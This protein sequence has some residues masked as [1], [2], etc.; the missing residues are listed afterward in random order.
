MPR[1]SLQIFLTSRSD[2]ASTTK[3]YVRRLSTSLLYDEFWMDVDERTMF[4]FESADLPVNHPSIRDGYEQ[5]I[6]LRPMQSRVCQRRDRW[7]ASP[8]TLLHSFTS[9]PCVHRGGK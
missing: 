2:M 8:A 9:G 7:C 4:L 5:N 3:L 1:W 6:E